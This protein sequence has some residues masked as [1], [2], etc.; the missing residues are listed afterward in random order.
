MDR[1]GLI[2]ISHRRASVE[3]IGWFAQRPSSLSELRSLL[4]VDELFHVVTCNRVELYWVGGHGR[5]SEKILRDYADWLFPGDDDRQRLAYSA[6]YTLSGE[7]VHRHLYSVVCGLDS[8]V[9]GDDQVVGQVKRAI[10]ESMKEDACGPWLGMFG[11]E[12]LKL[13][14]R[15]RSQVDFQQCASSVSE[16]AALLLRKEVRDLEHARVVMIGAGETIGILAPRLAGWK[17]TSLHFVNRTGSA[18]RKLAER[19][20]GTWQ[21]LAEFQAEPVDFDCMATATASPDPV[22]GPEHLA[23]LPTP[24]RSR[25]ILDLGVP[26]DTDPKLADSP[27]VRRSDLIEIGRCA[28]EGS[29]EAELVIREV[30]PYLRDAVVHFRER[31]FRRQL[32]PIASKLRESVTERAHT[33]ADKWLGGP[34]AHLSV[35][36]KEHVRRF[37]ARL[38][39]Q[40]VQVPLVALRKT[41]RDLPMGEVLLERMRDAGRKAAGIEE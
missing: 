19:H 9:L 21:P 41:L 26:A 39:D 15:V 8:L 36:D 18:A 7:A 34:L 24:E 6:C 17:S 4:G 40:T 1:F 12:A 25:L 28:D 29:R 33:E 3:E 20:G 38:A 27:H 10:A 14:R 5:E 31:V 11:D 13:A 23:K 37:A 32:N 16:V 30:R 22:F 35:E 2:G